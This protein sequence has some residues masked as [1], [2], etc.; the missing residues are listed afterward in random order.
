MMDFTKH[1]AT[2]LRALV[3]PQGAPIAGTAQVPNRA[4]GFAWAVDRWARLDRFLVLGTEGGTYYVGER[5]LTVESATAVAECIAH[6]GARVVRRIVEISEAGRAPRNDP[7]LFALAMAAGLGDEATRAAALDALPRVARTGTHLLHWLQSM[8][9]FRGW[10][11]GVRR[12]VGRWY[13]FPGQRGFIG[14]SM[15]DDAVIV[16]GTVAPED[17]EVA[18]VQRDALFSTVHGAGRVMSRTEA[19]GKRTRKGMV[20]SHGKIQPKMVEDW[21]ARKGVVLRGGGLDEAPQVYRRLPKVLEAQGA[22]IEV[23]HVLHPLVV[24]MAGAGEIDP[25]KD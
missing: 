11:R 22:T 9:A 3:T 17:S 5:E 1:F 21:L 14:G 23:Q 13:T 7:A 19:A 10:G 24:V 15:G 25:Y 18:A 4:G 8:Q 6:D 12:A 16:A 2:R 20:K